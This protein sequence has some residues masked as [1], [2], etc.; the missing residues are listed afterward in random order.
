MHRSATPTPTWKKVALLVVTTLLMSVVV[1]S[2]VRVHF[3]GRYG[4]RPRFRV[5]DAKLTWKPGANID[6]L[7]YGPDYTVHV[8][9]DGDGYR[10]G[11]LG[12]PSGDEGL[13]LLSGDSYAFGWGVSTEET[14]ASFLDEMLHEESG[15]ETRLV[16][17]GVGGYGIFQSA[18]RLQQ[19]LDDRP[20][21]DV[22]AVVFV[23]F[24]NDAADNARADTLATYLGYRR[25]V[26][27]GSP[28]Q[29][30][31]PSHLVNLVL[32]WRDSRSQVDARI[33]AEFPTGATWE[34]ELPDRFRVGTTEFQR[35]QIVE[36]G[37]DHRLTLKRKSLAE[38]E[39]ALM[40]ESIAALHEAAR[41]RGIP[42][43]HTFVVT[44]PEWYV[45]AVSR[46][47]EEAPAHGNE[48]R[49][50]GSVPA[51]RPPGMKRVKNR[52]KGGHFTPEMNR[53]WAAGL[54]ELLR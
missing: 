10:L 14:A 29:N 15:G 25:L 11:R 35:K 49:V 3:G 40:R 21:A 27:P 26:D 54:Y 4:T 2:F 38:F 31:T 7:F 41:G 18:G 8:R 50:A 19:F 16:N 52:H 6:S 23:H 42:I 17:L 32:H 28:I 12:E 1:E 37:H 39:I 5:A 33:F 48:I 46:I 30:A 53:A 9:T 20:D 24:G 43:H 44:D 13:V 36:E 47:V 22:R 45:E 51:V 34:G